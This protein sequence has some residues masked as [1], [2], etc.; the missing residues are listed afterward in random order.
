MATHTITIIS[1]EH[2]GPAYQ[3]RKTS[4]GTIQQQ[5]PLDNL[6]VKFTVND[7]PEEHVAAGR[8]EA[9]AGRIHAFDPVNDHHDAIEAIVTGNVWSWTEFEPWSE[10]K[11]HGFGVGD[12]RI[13]V[14]WAKGIKAQATETVE[15]HTE[16]IESVRRHLAGEEQEPHLRLSRLQLPH[17]DTLK[18]KA[19]DEDGSRAR[20]TAPD[21]R[22]VG[23]DAPPADGGERRSE[24]EGGGAGD[25]GGEA[26]RQ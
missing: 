3:E 14:K 23:S 7:D 16:R 18:P 26:E 24:A 17:A 2:E 20:A 4:L 22:G 1:V 21:D 12:G 10:A 5:I 25:A 13:E 11:H 9:I 15:P 8:P 6:V 19:R